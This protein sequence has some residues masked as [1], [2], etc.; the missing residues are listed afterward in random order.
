M[1][2]PLP[3]PDR[4]FVY[5]NPPLPPMERGQRGVRVLYRGGWPSWPGWPKNPIAPPALVRPPHTLETVER[6]L[7]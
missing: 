7:K 5:F 3:Q 1:S 6:P 2:G 4:N